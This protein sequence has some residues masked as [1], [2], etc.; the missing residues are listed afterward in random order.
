MNSNIDL[1]DLKQGTYRVAEQDG[2]IE[3]MLGV[4]LVGTSF[5]LFNVAFLPFYILPIIFQKQISEWFRNK[6]TYPRIGKAEFKLEKP[7]ETIRG[8]FTFVFVTFILIGAALFLLGDISN[9]DSWYRWMTLFFGTALV[10][11]MT[12]TYSLSGDVKHRVYAVLAFIS[13]IIFFL[14]EFDS[15]KTNIT[16]YLFAIGIFFFLT[17]L[18]TF[19]TFLQK[20]PVKKEN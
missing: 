4:I 9:T 5:F 13:G 7:K 6:F 11:A 1:N 15:G 17:G 18:T 16:T 3:L 8:I 10:G 14:M 12:Y 2:F 20:H 19:Y